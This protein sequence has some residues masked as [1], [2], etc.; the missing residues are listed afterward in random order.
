MGGE[1]INSSGK[2]EPQRH[3]GCALRPSRVPPPRSVHGASGIAKVARPPAWSRVSTTLCQM[4]QRT[5]KRPRDSV[6]SHLGNMKEKV[7]SSRLVSELLRDERRETLKELGGS[8]E[9]GWKEGVAWAGATVGSLGPG[10]HERTQPVARVGCP[11][12][13]RGLVDAGEA[14]FSQPS[15]GLDLPSLK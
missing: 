9:K 15:H 5:F 14:G 10:T 3:P 1:Q 4:L 12:C 8:G 7:R 2:A 11:G 13:N 6:A